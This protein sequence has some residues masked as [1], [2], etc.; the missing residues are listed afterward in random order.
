M[1]VAAGAIIGVLAVA[2]ILR[3]TGERGLAEGAI[4][5]AG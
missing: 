5:E 4:G 1:C 3:R 2:V